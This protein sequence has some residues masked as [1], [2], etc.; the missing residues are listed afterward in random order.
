MTDFVHAS[1]LPP[2]LHGLAAVDQTTIKARCGK[3]VKLDQSVSGPGVTCP[4]C[5]KW[6]EQHAKAIETLVDKS[7]A[8]NYRAVWGI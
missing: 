7:S 6:I 4:D 2:S 8:A 5:L 3:R 1:H